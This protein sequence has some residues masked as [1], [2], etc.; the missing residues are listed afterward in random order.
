MQSLELSVEVDLFCGFFHLTAHLRLIDTS[1]FL[2]KPVG[3]RSSSLL[4]VRR[5]YS[6]AC[7]MLPFKNKPLLLPS[8]PVLSTVLPLFFAPP[9]LSSF[10]WLDRVKTVPS[11]LSSL[12]PSAK[13]MSQTQPFISHQAA[14]EDL[15]TAMRGG[16][17]QAR[18]G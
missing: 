1:P 2:L 12:Q 4:C 8:L 7:Y 5:S 6:R 14:V 16:G 9:C 11:V 18:C 17:L 13:L 3:L 15:G 10:L